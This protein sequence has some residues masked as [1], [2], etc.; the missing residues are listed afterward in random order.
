MGLSMHDFLLGITAVK[1]VDL[2]RVF[3]SFDLNL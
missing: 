2:I 3:D 1:K